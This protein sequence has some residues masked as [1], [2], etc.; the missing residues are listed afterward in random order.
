MQQMAMELIVSYHLVKK[1]IIVLESPFGSF[2]S[3]MSFHF[4]IKD[5]EHLEMG[6]M[7]S[8]QIGREQLFNS[9][10]DRIRTRP[11]WGEPL[12]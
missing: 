10:Q 9:L 12:G 7:I 3:V 4:T 1:E 11:A 5:R 2:R 8:G 6:G